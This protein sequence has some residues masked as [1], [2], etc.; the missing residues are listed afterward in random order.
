MPFE[1]EA[2]VGYLYVVGGRSISTTPP[3]ALV[4]AAPKRAAR[5]RETDTF[6]A[7]ALP[8]GD[9]VAPA[10]F[11]ETMVRTAADHYFKS[12]GSVTAGLREV[13]T[14][15]NY[16]LVEQ[17]QSA[18]TRYTVDILCAVLRGTDLIVGRV[19]GCVTLFRSDGK[20]QSFPDDLADHE[21]LHSTPLG[22][23]PMPNIKMTQYRLQSGTR[24][25]F[26]DAGLAG[27]N[28]E[29]MRN[30]LLSVDVGATLLGLKE[31]A[32]LQ[33]TLIVA[34]FVSPQTPSAP[35]IPEGQSTT[36]LAAKARSEAERPRPHS[37]SGRP[38]RR[39]E[40]LG[41]KIRRAIK[42][43]VGQIV[44]FLARGLLLLD[45]LT[46]HFFGAKDSGGHGWLAS[47]I[48]LGVVFLLPLLVVGAVVILW[49]A[50][51]G[52]SE[53]DFCA[54]EV[55][56]RVNNVALSPNV[57]NSDR[58]TITNAWTLVLD[59][60]NRCNQLRPNDPEL[61][62]YYRQG[63]EVLDTLN[64]IIRQ[65]VTAI[66]AP[67]EA[68][69]TQMAVQGQNLYILDSTNMQ[70]Y[71]INL[72]I[73]GMQSGFANP[74]SGMR[75]DVVVSGYPVGEIFDIAFDEDQN[76]IVAIDRNGVVVECS[77]QFLEC[78][79][80]QLQGTENWG[81]PV[82][83]TIWGG[84]IYILDPG[85][86]YGQIWRYERSGGLYNNAP[87]EYFGGVSAPTITSAIDFAID[88]NGSIYVLLAEGRVRKYQSGEAQP[89]DFNAFPEGQDLVSATAMFLDDRPQS[90]NLYIVD[91]YRRAIHET[92]LIG[93]FRN[94]YHTFNESYF[95]LLAVMVVT[96]MGN[97]DIM[98]IA[99]GNTVFAMPKP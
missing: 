37:E 99:S 30:A 77:P 48:G 73:D 56:D 33:A 74:I 79:A 19:G 93:N 42:R 51:T 71:V 63:Q 44:L 87:T 20:I 18:P 60:I 67:P 8:S 81:N 32:R 95:D 2:L 1:L 94:S 5:G 82:A 58:L 40:G 26:G 15:L 86:G 39:R 16:H 25:I 50:N 3:G 88:G 55:R 28:R 96:Q 46:D 75:R 6:F 45:K 24:V 36:E 22:V 13:F 89:F 41:S 11:Y 76:R 69:L 38:Q 14:V 43:R 64:Q 65:E 9:T 97:R 59:Q 72:S 21:A 12:G 70:V 29:Q 10:T 83:A 49:I 54:Q 68:T 85:V 57:V 53:F 47:P 78:A 91:R 17:N 34:E 23:L 4:E 62:A 80:Q 52:E 31:L 92:S 84:R 7:L 98:Y 90:Q 66:A 35:L 27:W 61:A